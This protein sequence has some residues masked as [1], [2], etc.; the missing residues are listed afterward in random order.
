[1]VK[2]LRINL[3]TKQYE[4]EE[5][6]TEYLMLGGR[7][8]IGKIMLDEVDPTCHPLE[9]QNKLIFANGLFVGSSF[10]C[11]GRLSIGAKSPL[12]GGIK[13]SNVGGVVATRM[14]HLGFRAIVVE[15]ISEEKDL[16]ALVISKDN[17]E[18]VDVLELKGMG[19]YETVQKLMERWG[20]K[21]A[22][23]TIGPA[24]E[25]LL[26]AASIASNDLY[27]RPSRHAGRG[28]MGAV[29]GSK[30]VKALVFLKPDVLEQESI[31]DLAEFNRINREFTKLLIP[32]K[33]ALTVL[34]TAGIVN[35]ANQV[36]GL[37]T[38]NFRFGR[39]DQ[40][41]EIGGEHMYDI[42]TSRPNG[43]PTESCL[44]GCVIRC[45]NVYVDEEG[46]YITSG[47]EYET[48][49]LNGSNLLIGDLDKIAQ[50]DRTCDDIGLDSMEM[51]N[52]MAIAME[53]GLLEWGDADGVLALLREVAE[54]T[55]KGRLMASGSAT[56]GK[57]L[58]VTRVPQCKGQGFAAYDPRVFKAMGVTYA[59]SPMGADHTSGPA[60]A[61]R[62]GWDPERN[63][64]DLTESEGKVEL[65]RE[66]EIMVSIC[67]AFGFCYFVGPD[68]WVME[69]VAK[70]INAKYN[71]DFNFEK[72]VQYGKRILLNEHEFNIRAGVPQV[73][74]LPAFFY[75]EELLPLNKRFDISP[76]ELK[77]AT[78]F[79][80]EN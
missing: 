46:N 23:L 6:K 50:I 29:L 17:V 67:D 66:L 51:G 53:A 4:F 37:P 64:G 19:N 43:I 32:K 34:G 16:L 39:F 2:L 78:D 71:W 68:R 5:L 58:G 79:L 63:Y 59:T 38:K 28:G 30:R 74:R 25:M 69:H 27:G 48:I 65:C 42:I 80:T 76:E 75:E 12:T 61:G 15:E 21:I 45:S 24:G 41:K 73:Y 1:M 20:N 47:L 72:I 18:F 62:T 36:G 22:T 10:P 60:L 44:P 14:G 70:A 57:V 77:E 9:S 40:A 3:K 26:A 35:T 52:A 11:A 56:A 33:R 13:E 31:E 49:A 8:L 54:G 7:A 55:L